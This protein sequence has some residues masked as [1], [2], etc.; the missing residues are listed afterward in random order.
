M[1]KVQALNKIF[2]SF[3][4]KSIEDY[5]IKNEEQLQKYITL[6]RRKK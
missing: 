5:D 4:S 1:E 6:Q 2:E 3:D